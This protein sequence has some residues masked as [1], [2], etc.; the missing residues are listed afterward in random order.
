MS[1]RR[2]VYPNLMGPSGGDFYFEQRELPEVRL[3]PLLHF[4]TADGLAP[5]A[6]PCGHACPANCIALNGTA[7]CAA[8]V[9][10]P[11]MDECNVGLFYAPTSKLRRQCA[12]DHII[13]RYDKQAASIFVQAMHDARPQLAR[14]RR[15]CA[16][17]VQQSVDKGC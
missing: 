16:E 3:N 9:F 2:D 6:A 4:V 10:Q 14:D 7:D 12:M 17:V 11:S 5:A 1:Q 13:L 15:Q 8:V